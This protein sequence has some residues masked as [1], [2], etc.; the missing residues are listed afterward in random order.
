M[1]GEFRR[2]DGNSGNSP[3]AAAQTGGGARAGLAALGRHIQA[4]RNQR[5][6][7]LEAMAVRTGLS[8]SYLSRIEN[9]KKTP[10]LGTLDRIAHALGTDINVLL[11]GEAA[12]AEPV[13]AYGVVRAGSRPGGRR[14][15]GAER[16]TPADAPLRIEPWLLRPGCEFVAPSLR[17]HV[18]QLFLHV[19]RGCVECEIGRERVDLSAGDSL[20]LDAR[21]PLRL[22]APKA[23]AEA[24]LVLVPRAGR[25]ARFSAT[26][27]ESAHDAAAT[28]AL[29]RGR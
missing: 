25:T 18:G 2:E 10:P 19:Q 9:G 26:S 4:R 28:P 7:T 1:F 12:P 24:L 17:D 13:P 23:D 22:R 14:A 3:D 21:L 11:A 27:G 20:H 6:I 8:K 15:D 29:D 16:L 5:G